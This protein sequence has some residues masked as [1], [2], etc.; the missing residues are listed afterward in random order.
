MRMVPSKIN[1]SLRRG[2]PLDFVSGNNAG[3]WCIDANPRQAVEDRFDH[4]RKS[5]GEGNVAVEQ[6]RGVRRLALAEPK[7]YR[8]GPA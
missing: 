5:P 3:E 8:D 1:P 4:D 2:G 7:A 6:G